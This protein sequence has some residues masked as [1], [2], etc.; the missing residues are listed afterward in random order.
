MDWR[1][2]RLMRS[3][4]TFVAVA[5]AAGLSIPGNPQRAGLDIFYSN[6]S[7]VF[8]GMDG[9]GIAD[10]SLP[11]ITGQ[12]PFRLNLA[13]NGDLSTRAWR[14]FNNGAGTLNV[15]FIEHFAPEWLLNLGLKQL[16]DEYNQKYSP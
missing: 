9:F 3:V 6:V 15:M 14:L 8:C 1:I 7:T 12:S 10:A 11:I 4:P 16:Q 5:P 2:G 13:Q